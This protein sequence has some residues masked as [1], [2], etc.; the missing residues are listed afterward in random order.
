MRGESIHKRHTPTR[1]DCEID[2]FS[3]QTQRKASALMR[4]FPFDCD[5]L[6]W[7]GC[8]GSMRRVGYT[9]QPPALV[10]PWLDLPSVQES[11][12]APSIFWNLDFTT[13]LFLSLIPNPTNSSTIISHQN[14]APFNNAAL[15]SRRQHRRSTVASA[16]RQPTRLE[17]STE[18]FHWATR[19]CSPRQEPSDWRFV[20]AAPGRGIRSID[21]MQSNMRFRGKLK[22]NGAAETHWSNPHNDAWTRPPRFPQLPAMDCRCPKPRT[23]S[24]YDPPMSALPRHARANGGTMAAV[25]DKSHSCPDAFRPIFSAGPLV[26]RC[27]C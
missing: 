13:T 9:H 10:A 11:D 16:R 17:C 3:R 4:L 7:G 27:G 12:L 18:S 2:D 22:A 26:R 25:L 21:S 14:N 20:Q 5:G 24:R 1:L 23:T 6:I 8:L 19:V 15:Q